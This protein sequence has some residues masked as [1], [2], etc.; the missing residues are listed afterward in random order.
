[1]GIL[2][3]G[4]KP[5][6]I[7]YNGAES[8]L[9][10]N[11]SK[12]WPESSPAPTFDEVTIGTQIWLAKNLSIDDGQGG[13][14]TQTVDYGQGNVVECFYTWEAANRVANSITG[15]HLPSQEEWATLVNYMGG[16]TVAGT[17]LK[18]TYGWTNTVG[19]DNYGFT[20]LPAGWYGLNNVYRDFGTISKIWT[21]TLYRNSTTSA[22]IRQFNYTSNATETDA[23]FK[24]YLS[25]RLIKDAA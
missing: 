17:K 6:K 24:M 18:A 3:N 11:G 1:M 16:Y 10:F 12:I 22:Y 5:S 8:S 23:P 15:W 13:I 20:V 2:V 4:N 7:I 19:T 14:N 25:V 9:Y 21:S